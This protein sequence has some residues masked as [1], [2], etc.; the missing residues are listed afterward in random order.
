MLGNVE[1]LP[2]KESLKQFAQSSSG[3][4]FLRK[5]DQKKGTEAQTFVHTTAQKHLQEGEVEQA[6]KILLLYIQECVSEK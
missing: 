4:S 6:W 5:I 1:A 2:S 3:Q